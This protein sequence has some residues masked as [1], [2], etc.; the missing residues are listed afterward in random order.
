ML[1][2]LPALAEPVDPP[3]PDPL[4]VSLTTGFSVRTAHFRVSDNAAELPY[5]GPTPPPSARLGAAWFFLKYFGVVADASGEWFSVG[6]RDEAQE[7]KLGNV[8]Y[9][10]TWSGSAGVAGRI[11]PVSVLSLELHLGWAARGETQVKQGPDGRLIDDPVFHQG[12]YGTFAVGIHPNFPIGF[13]AWARAAPF[14]AHQAALMQGSTALP[15]GTVTSWYAFGAEVTAGRMKLSLLRAS[16]VL[17]YEANLRR[18]VQPGGYRFTETA[19]NISLGVRVSMPGPPVDEGPPVETLNTPG[20]LAGTVTAE[21]GSPIW[22]A[23]VV[24]NGGAALETD[25]QGQFSVP[26]LAAGEAKVEVTAEGFKPGTQTV[27]VASGEAATVKLT[28]T[29]PT[30]PGKVKGKVTLTDPDRPAAGAEVWVEGGPKV[31]AGDDGSY[32]LEGV[33]P[34]PIALK[35]GTTGYVPSEQMVS[36]PAEDVANVDIKLSNKRPSAVLRGKVSVKEGSLVSATVKVKQ[37]NLTVNVG[38]DGSFRI[39]LPG[40]RYDIVV[41]APGYRTQTRTIDVGYGDQ[42]IFH[43]ELRPIAR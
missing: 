19:H 10:Y 11:A 21:D 38:A 15:E 7:A 27:A 35:A 24:V 17:Q 34:G 33:G 1:A 43:F 6:P 8:P 16:L 29:R 42:T 41:E 26:S 30:G 23:K 40:G 4:R 31:T 3:G 9:A 18:S 22:K 13:L 5:G 12:P 39:E 28:L 32:L 2:G 25:A 37:K 14:S 20:S 36:V